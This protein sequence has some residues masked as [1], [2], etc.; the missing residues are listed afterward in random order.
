M[1]TADWL[2]TL[3]AIRSR[4][5]MVYDAGVK[6]ELHHFKLNFDRLDELTDYVY[7]VTKDNYPNFQ[8]PYHARW[9][10]F[11]LQGDNLWDKISRTLAVDSE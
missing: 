10:H 8:I 9:R 6:D 7:K 4:C 5:S 1:G 11:I 3:E 2:M